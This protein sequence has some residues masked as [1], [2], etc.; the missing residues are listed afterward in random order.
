M[1]QT[2]EKKDEG[3]ATEGCMLKAELS[4]WDR[5]LFIFTCYRQFALSRDQ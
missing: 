5:L 1:A 3:W 2:A 4:F